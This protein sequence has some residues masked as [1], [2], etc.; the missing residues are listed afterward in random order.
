M[1]TLWK[2]GDIAHNEQFLLFPHSVF[3]PLGELSATFLKLEIV[4]C[5]LIQF[6]SVWNLS[7]GKG[8]MRLLFIKRQN[9]RLL[10]T[11][12]ICR[13]QNKCDSKIEVCHGMRR[14]HC[15]KRRKCWWPAFSPFPTMFSKAFSF[16][17]VKSRDCVVKGYGGNIKPPIA[18]Q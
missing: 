18:R 11:G 9:S 3:Y 12:S 14:K 4:I 2:K 7:V 15:G 16:R 6:G 1:K 5:N 8:M 13:R 10:Q 17:V